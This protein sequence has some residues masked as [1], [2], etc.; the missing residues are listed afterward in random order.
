MKNSCLI[1]SLTHTQSVRV[2]VQ[3][4]AAVALAAVMAVMTAGCGT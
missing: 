1:T 3:K 4:T 2:I